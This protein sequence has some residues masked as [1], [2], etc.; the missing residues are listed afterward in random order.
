MDRGYKDRKIIIIY[1]VLWDLKEVNELYPTFKEI[2]L[3]KSKF[4]LEAFSLSL[5]KKYFPLKN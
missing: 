1:P 3:F 2:N 4:Y 5:L